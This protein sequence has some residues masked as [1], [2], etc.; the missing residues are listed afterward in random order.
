MGRVFA[1]ARA[2]YFRLLASCGSRLAEVDLDVIQVCEPMMVG[3][4]RLG[5]ENVKNLKERPK[6]LTKRRA[7]RGD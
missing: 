7:M 4:R 1:H 3:A 6:K 2:R 5:A